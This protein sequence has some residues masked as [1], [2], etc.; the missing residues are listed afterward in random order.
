[1]L[2]EYTCKAC[3]LEWTT[4]QRITEDPLT[5]CPLCHQPT[6]VRLISGSAFVLKGGG[7]AKENYSK[8]GSDPGFPK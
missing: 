8:S 7:W 1:M 6:A 4:E 5:V 3:N 2:Y